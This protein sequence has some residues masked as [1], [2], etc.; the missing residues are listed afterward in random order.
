MGVLKGKIALIT[1]GSRGIGRAIVESFAREGATVWFTYAAS[2]EQA[3]ALSAAIT[4]SGGEAKAVQ[5]DGKEVEAVNKLVQDILAQNG[6]LDILVNNAGITRDNLLLRMQDSQ[7]QEVIDNNL[8]AS[9]YY[10]RAAAKAML[11][12]GGSMIHLSSVVGL[13]G[14]AGQANYA[15]SK[16]G[17][18]G[19]SK[20][21]ALELGSRKVRSNVIAPGFI[22][23]ELTDVLPVETREAYIGQIPL[24]EF[25]TPED[26]AALAVFLASDSSAYITGQVIS[27]C[28]GLN[29]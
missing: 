27:V 20:S 18:I 4:A 26:V 23:T 14:N 16:A 8:S 12:T 9:F 7:W 2:G 11:R 25:G 28:G 6:R 5:C 10:C 24:K 15:A 3:A 1:G 22:A 19:L 29:H 21:V 17:L 13:H